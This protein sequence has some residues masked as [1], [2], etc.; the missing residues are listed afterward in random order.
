[1]VSVLEQRHLISISE[2]QELGETNYFSSSSH[3]ELIDGEIFEMAPIG[4]K[5]S[6]HLKRLNALLSFLV[7][8]R[9]VVGV[10][11]PVQLGDFSEPEPDL[12]LLKLSADFYSSRHPQADDVLLIVEVSDSTL[13]FDRFQ[14][15][16]LYALHKIPEYWILNLQDECLEVYRQPNASEYLEKLTL[17]A[18]DQINLL[19]FEDICVQVQELF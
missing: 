6:G 5:H 3:I 7:H 1:M 19:A 13:P 14:K 17:R 15:M 18:G 4:F 16:R 11:D 9:A 12:S 2:W 8:G 10:Q